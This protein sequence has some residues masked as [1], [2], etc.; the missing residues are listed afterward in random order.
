ML[1]EKKKRK[2][3]HLSNKYPYA[4]TIRKKKKERKKKVKCATLSLA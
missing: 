2:Y 1:T 4:P 3:F